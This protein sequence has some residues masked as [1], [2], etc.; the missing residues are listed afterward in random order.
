MSRPRVVENL[1]TAAR[2]DETLT[3]ERRVWLLPV[4]HASMAE[5]VEAIAHLRGPE[6][7]DLIRY[8]PDA[9]LEA[10]FAAHPPLD[11]GDSLG[12]GFRSDASLE[13]LVRDAL[14]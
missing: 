9:A 14:R 6:V 5:V 4:L 13:T 8:E 10:Q 2:L 11:A 3:G 1:L 12:A 7:F